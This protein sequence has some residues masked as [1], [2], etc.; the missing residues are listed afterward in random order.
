MCMITS[1]LSAIF[2]GT[3]KTGSESKQCFWDGNAEGQGQRFI[4]LRCGAFLQS[5]EFEKKFEIIS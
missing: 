3:M 1:A 4:F 5:F 2:W